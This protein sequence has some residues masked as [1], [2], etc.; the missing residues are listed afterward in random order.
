[1]KLKKSVLKRII[2][3]E[4]ER[5][6]LLESSSESEQERRDRWREHAKSGKPD[7]EEPGYADFKRG[8]LSVYNPGKYVADS[9]SGDFESEPEDEQPQGD[10]DF[11]DD[12][13]ASYYLFWVKGLTQGVLKGPLSDSPSEIISAGYAIVM[14]GEGQLDTFQLFSPKFWGKD[15]NLPN[16][17]DL[18]GNRL[19]GCE[20][21][22]MMLVAGAI[23]K[24]LYQAYAFLGDRTDRVLG[25][26][27][28]S[29]IGRRRFLAISPGLTGEDVKEILALALTLK[30]LRDHQPTADAITNLTQ[31]LCSIK[32]M[33]SGYRAIER[34]IIKF[35]YGTPDFV[36]D[37]YDDLVDRLG[38]ASQDSESTDGS[39][40]AGDSASDLI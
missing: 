38:N 35:V 18:N 12:I 32:D 5:G 13:M 4:I 2:L 15:K 34:I 21:T 10:S 37:V 16:V 1:M 11:V 26:R 6:T 17:K 28:R 39:D 3:E 29:L 33:D 20:A 22:A 19:S 30:T 8:F 31:E 40:S 14:A 24:K 36:L 7:L 27:L 23:Y 9:I 25:A